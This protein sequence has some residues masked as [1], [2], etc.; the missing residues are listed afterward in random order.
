MNTKEARFFPPAIIGK[1]EI[2]ILAHC[3]IFYA[4]CVCVC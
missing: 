4:V 2:I 3:Y 1:W